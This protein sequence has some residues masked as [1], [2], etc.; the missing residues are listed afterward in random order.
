MSDIAPPLTLGRLR[1]L[2][3]SIFSHTDTARPLSTAH[4]QQASLV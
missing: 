1:E 4:D 3:L 2:D